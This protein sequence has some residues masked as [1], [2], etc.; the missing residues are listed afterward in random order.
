MKR[1][2]ER[3]VWTVQTPQIFSYD[4]IKKAHEEYRKKIMTAITDDAMVVEQGKWRSS[5]TCRGLLS[6]Y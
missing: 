5:K 3:E 6:E 1:Q 2:T 4:L